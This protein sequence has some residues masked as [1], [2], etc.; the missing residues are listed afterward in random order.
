MANH[1]QLNNIEHKDLK[2]ITQR[3]PEYGDDL[4]YALIV[5]QEFRAV[6]SCY[7]IF[8][9]KDPT[10]AKFFALSLFGFQQGEN[11]FLDNTGW[12]ADYIPLSVL[13]QPF[14]IGKQNFTED[15]QEQSRRV[16]HID[17]DSNRVSTTT[18]EPLFKEF[19]GNTAYLDRVAGVLETLHKGLLESEQF[20][21]M[22]LAQDLLEP[23]TLSVTLNDGSAH[24]L[25]GFYTI[26]EEKL[27]TLSDEAIIKLYRGGYLEAIYMILGSHARVSFLIE[28]KNRLIQ[29]RNA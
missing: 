9:Q 2:V 14:L 5:P 1:V 27:K 20:I 11:L 12:N 19:G 13:R 21:N 29:A 16:I 25:I 8:F 17:M 7:P 6:Q 18:G 15:G 22:L 26:N 10:T 4:W 28:Q 3:S 23:F 24:Q